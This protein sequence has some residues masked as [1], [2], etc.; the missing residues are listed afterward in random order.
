MSEYR[1]VHVL[2]PVSREV[3]LELE[4]PRGVIRR[5]RGLI[6]RDSLPSGGGMAFR[7][8]QIHTVRMRIPIDAVYVSRR[9]VILK[10][11]TLAPGSLGPFVPRARW[12][13]EVG[14]GE[15]ERLGLAEGRRLIVERSAS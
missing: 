11:S 3:L 4:E 1:Q 6:G 2:D 15:A 12:V 5:M 7:S 10:I 14:A 9:G 8:K 13:L